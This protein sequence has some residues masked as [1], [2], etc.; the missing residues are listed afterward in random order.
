MCG[1]DRFIID[2]YADRKHNENE[3]DAHILSA[4]IPII[5]EEES[6][7]MK[8]DY[9]LVL[10]RYFKKAFLKENVQSTGALE[11]TSYHPRINYKKVIGMKN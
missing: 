7:A 8:P 4:D 3:H 1:I 6:R 11:Q 5:N 2:N 9:C 10:L